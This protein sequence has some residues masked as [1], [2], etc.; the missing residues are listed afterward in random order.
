[1]ALEAGTLV[2]ALADAICEVA[3]AIDALRRVMLVL[4]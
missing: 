4:P 1:M 3:L 2:L